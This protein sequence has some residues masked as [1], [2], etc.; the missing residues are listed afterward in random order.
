VV[1]SWQKNTP[2]QFKKT[3]SNPSIERRGRL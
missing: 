1:A 2:K 3:T